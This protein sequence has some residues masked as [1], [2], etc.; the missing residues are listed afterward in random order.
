VRAV[1]DGTQYEVVDRCYSKVFLRSCENEDLG[2]L[3]R[4][5]DILASRG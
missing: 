3:V 4:P 5:F 2:A 1:F